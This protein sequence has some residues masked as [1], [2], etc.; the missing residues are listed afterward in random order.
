[1]KAE[2]IIQLNE[3]NLGR[4]RERKGR[5]ERTMTTDCTGGM[6]A[7]QGVLGLFHSFQRYSI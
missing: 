2:G 7:I 1:M 4:E 5:E 3:Q 6:Q